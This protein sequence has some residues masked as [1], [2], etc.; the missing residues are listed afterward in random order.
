[1]VL[2]F[3]LKLVFL[4]VAIKGAQLTGK[5]KGWSLTHLVLPIDSRYVFYHVPIVSIF[6]FFARCFMFFKK[7]TI[8]YLS[9]NVVDIFGPQLILYFQTNDYKPFLKNWSIFIL[10]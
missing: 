1:M 10:L 5:K 6:F 2:F 7:I 8:I 9:F 3:Y 4:F